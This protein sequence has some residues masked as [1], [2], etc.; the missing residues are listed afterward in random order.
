M[1]S[2]TGRAFI[3]GVGGAALRGDRFRAGESRYPRAEGSLR[4]RRLPIL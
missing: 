1:V 2:K 4:A 3:E